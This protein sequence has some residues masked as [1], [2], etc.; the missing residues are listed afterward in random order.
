MA[1]MSRAGKGVE[2][3]GCAT[4]RI[5][6]SLCGRQEWTYVMSPHAPRAGSYSPP[7]TGFK[8]ESKVRGFWIFFTESALISAAVRKPKSTLPIADGIGCVIFIFK[9]YVHEA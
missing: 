2:I 6:S 3:A 8:R 9:V 5:V 7:G 1:H 4:M